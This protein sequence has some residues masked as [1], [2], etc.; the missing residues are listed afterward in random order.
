MESEVSQDIFCV[1]QRDGYG[2]EIV[3]ISVILFFL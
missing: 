3:F 2:T 1:L